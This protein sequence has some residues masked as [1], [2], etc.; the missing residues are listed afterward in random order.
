MLE[1]AGA[2][3]KRCA[4]AGCD[5]ILPTDV[6]VADALAE[7]AAFDVVAA[8]AVPHDK[9]I[10]DIG[11]ASVEELK[12]RIDDCRTLIWNGPVGAFETPP[13]DRGTMA[14]A[15]AVGNLTLLGTLTSVAGGGDTLAAL[16]KAGV[17][18]DLTYVSAAGGAFLEWLEG[19]TL[20]GIE[21]LYSDTKS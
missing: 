20:P 18:R 2:I 19:R 10:L 8:N 6:V 5:V 12:D 11:P 3:L 16:V 9:T 15:R 1:T 21:V 13:F 7:G 14:I 17:E 4:N